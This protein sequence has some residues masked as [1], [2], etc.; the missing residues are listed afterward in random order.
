MITKTV[1]IASDHAGFSVK[2]LLA[3]KLIQIGLEIC[4]LGPTSEDRVDYPDFADL[5]SESLRK[6]P[7]SLG[8]LVCGSGQGMAMRAN[9]YS[10]VRAALCWNEESAKL[11]RQHNDA[12]VLCVGARLIGKDQLLKTVEAFFK[13]EF[14]GGRHQGRVQKIS[15]PV[16]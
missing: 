14:E 7:G 5:V 8:L 2:A 4:D 13:S 16:G 11:S 15:F 1:Y 6:T 3:E 10:H 12:N 9:K